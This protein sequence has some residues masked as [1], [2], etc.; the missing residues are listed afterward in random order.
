VSGGDFDASASPP[1]GPPLDPFQHDLLAEFFP[2]PQVSARC[3]PGGERGEWGDEKTTTSG[4][5]R[6][7]VLA[8]VAVD[9]DRERERERGGQ[10][11]GG[12]GGN[13]NGISNS[14]PSSTPPR[15]SPAHTP[16]ASPAQSPRGA[17][18]GIDDLDSLEGVA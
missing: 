3:D 5:K 11:S 6:P 8:L 10:E 7:S 18:G 15:N 2:Q 9:G 4:G 17:K 14:S 16:R 13:G 12:L 1:L